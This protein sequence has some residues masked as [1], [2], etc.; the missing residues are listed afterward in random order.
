MDVFGPRAVVGMVHLLPLPGAPGWGGSMDEVL[1]RALM[2]ARTLADGGLHGVIVENYGDVPFYPMSVPP[3]TVAAMS[4]VV[5][6]VRKEVTIPVGVNVLRNDGVAALAVAVATGAVFVRVNVHTGSMFTDQGLLQG[7][8]HELLRRRA[9]LRTPL[10]V[11]ADV[12]VKHGTP[13]PGTRLE[14]AARDARHWGL[15]DVL[16]VSGDATGHATDPAAVARVKEAVPGV[17]VWVGSGA[18][19][20]TIGLHLR[21]ADGVIVGSAIEKDRIAGGPVDAERVRHLMDAAS[22]D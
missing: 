9:A 18:T 19:P 20:E 10:A 3:E 4:A 15:A 17:P 7:N 14:E 22:A 1:E 8:A 6:A 21:T 2:D 5:S 11:F 16:I 12:F 13:P